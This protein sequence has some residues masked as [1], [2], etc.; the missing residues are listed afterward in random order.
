MSQAAKSA[1]VWAA[2]TFVAGVALTGFP[3]ALLQLCRLPS[4]DPWIRIVG[5]LT[6]CISYLYLRAALEE[7]RAYMQWSVHTRAGLA[8]LFLALVLLGL[9][10][11]ILLIFGAID[12]VGAG[13]MQLALSRRRTSALSRGG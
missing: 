7:N 12:L 3:R 2:Y 8:T 9:A 10:P 5:A 13:W 4:D 1:M 11:G 6:L